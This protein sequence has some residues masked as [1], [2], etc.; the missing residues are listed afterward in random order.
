MTDQEP[1]KTDSR[2]T[3][4]SPDYTDG[5]KQDWDAEWN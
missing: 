3:K 4:M 1:D 5:W 2:K